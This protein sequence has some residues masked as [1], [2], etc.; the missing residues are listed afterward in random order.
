VSEERQALQ[1]IR[2]LHGLSS[3]NKKLLHCCK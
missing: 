2:G 1:K 3:F